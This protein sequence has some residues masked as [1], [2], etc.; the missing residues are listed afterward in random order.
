MYQMLFF[1]LR[2]LSSYFYMIEKKNGVFIV[3]VSW[4]VPFT[5][6]GSSV[7]LLPLTHENDENKAH[8]P[9]QVQADTCFSK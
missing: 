7:M 5:K 1:F 9:Q 8:N 2:E 6:Y 4:C 3:L